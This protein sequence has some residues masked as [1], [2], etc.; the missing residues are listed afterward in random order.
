MTKPQH[1]PTATVFTDGACLGNPGPGGWAAIIDADGERRELSGGFSRTTN[2]RMELLA[3]IEALEQL[4]EPRQVEL[5][6]D[7]RYLHDA[8]AKGWL[9]RW[10][11]NGWRTASK[12][13][14]KNQDLWKRLLPLIHK[15]RLTV[16]WTRGHHGHPE[17]ERCDLL[18]SRAAQAPT[19]NEDKAY[20]EQG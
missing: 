11:S 6:T 13:P 20:L 4:H 16:T 19:L 12:S 14:V 18:A 2:N 8:L 3:L 9:T 1:L 10:Q 7:S 17:N 5:V 15:H